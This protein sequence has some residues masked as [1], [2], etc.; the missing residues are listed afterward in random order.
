[1]LRKVCKIYGKSRQL[2]WWIGSYAL[3]MVLSIL[4]NMIGYVV[5]IEVIENE[6]EK[7]H[8]KAITNM[9]TVLDGYISELMTATGRLTQTASVKSSLNRSLSGYSR[10]K[11]AENVMR[12]IEINLIQNRL[13]EDCGIIMRNS[14]ICIQNG[15][16][17]ISLQMA[18]DA[19][20]S[21]YYPSKDEWLDSVFSVSGAE[22]LS[23]NKKSVNTE[24]TDADNGTDYGVDL[25]NSA[26]SQ[27]FLVYRIPTIYSQVA[28]V[29]K[30][31]ESRIIKTLKDLAP[32]SE[33]AYIIDNEENILYASENEFDRAQI[34]DLI[35]KSN[36]YHKK[37]HM[38]YTAASDVAPFS[39]VR[40]IEKLEYMREI[41]KVRISFIIG[42]ILCVLIVGCVILRF[43]NINYIQ[44]NKL[45][46]KM[47]AQRRYVH[48]VILRRILKGQ[49]KKQ[50]EIPDEYRV[51]FSGRNFAVLLFDYLTINEE[52]EE[53]EKEIPSS[54]ILL[55]YLTT[56][57]SA[58]FGEDRI[59]FC[60]IND[61]CVCVIRTDDDSTV[62]NRICSI[63]EEIC[64]T[65]EKD[66]NINVYC[67]IGYALG[68]FRE[69][70]HA[71]E[72]AL[73]TVTFKFLGEDKTVFV[74]D[75]ISGIKPKNEFSPRLEKN[76][77]NCISA[78]DYYNAEQIIKE[79]L[80][81]SNK[82]QNVSFATLKMTFDNIVKIVLQISAQ[83]NAEDKI[84]SKSLYMMS[85][86]MSS[87]SQLQGMCDT[88][89]QSVKILCSSYAEQGSEKI[90]DKYYI[91]CEYIHENY[92]NQNLNV[93]MI[94]DT[95]KMN[96]TWLSKI[97]KEKNGENISEYIVKYRLEKAKELLK[98]DMKISQIAAA[99]GFSGEIVYCRAF[100]KYEGL[101]SVQYRQYL[102]TNENGP[103]NEE[104]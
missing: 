18:Y 78:G 103:I 40:I 100:K 79:Q 71:Y 54:N 16:G 60:L 3:I 95:F 52:M 35:T 89:L 77:L 17:V 97:F 59:S 92:M 98:T 104:K 51:F 66:L 74:Y 82:K 75:D 8:Q 70:H 63:T 64:R 91:I 10:Q 58:H 33:Y 93:N 14:D 9:K 94:A 46:L 34:K 12:D 99:V 69:I 1:M 80:A 87:V 37:N 81:L 24:Q 45:E 4:I 90:N 50:D 101:T 36:D 22:F 32:K 41:R 85:V 84:D 44:K 29:S 7:N 43:A 72:K 25:Y 67:G 102:M 47:K 48:Q 39:Y 6:V 38:I 27:N 49:I 55:S 15:L 62:N 13:A 31:N 83:I 2:Y 73:E 5:S 61:M 96:R 28:I 42:Y 86:K 23:I 26:G 19:Y 30:V 20:Y 88:I 56:L 68:G 76:L 65:I 53:L 21:K 57:F 11:A